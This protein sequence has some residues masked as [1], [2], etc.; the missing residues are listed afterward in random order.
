[1]QGLTRK[2]FDELLKQHAYTVALAM[3]TAAQPFASA[4]TLAS[5]SAPEC[6]MLHTSHIFE[7]TSCRCP[8]SCCGSVLY[9]ISIYH[10]Q[11]NATVRLRSDGLMTL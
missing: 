5:A 11:C 6:D 9:A 1:M 7:V 3:E 2:L 8:S 4:R 10:T